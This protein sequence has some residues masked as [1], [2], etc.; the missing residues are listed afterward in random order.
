[1]EEGVGSEIMEE[2]VSFQIRIRATAEGKSR[3]LTVAELGV[4]L[5]GINRALNKSAGAALMPR[6]SPQSQEPLLVRSEILGV[7]NGSVLLSIV[8]AISD[9]T[10]QNVLQATFL[11]GIF[12]N[13]AWD[14]SKVLSKD[15][16][17][18]LRRIGNEVKEEKVRV[19]PVFKS[20]RKLDE[21]GNADV[22]STLLRSKSDRPL[23]KLDEI[24]H[25]VVPS[26][27]QKSELVQSLTTVETSSLHT[28]TTYSVVFEQLG[29]PRI[30][31]SVSVSDRD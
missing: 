25:E 22:P 29:I 13:A 17:H 11:A 14:F 9:F 18:A 10:Q 26:K 16:V 30:E 7:E 1:M 23:S 24:E 8:S 28:T 6:Y 19:D 20:D 5:T 15:I 31:I 2:T 27:E 3:N 21:I 12:G 4:L